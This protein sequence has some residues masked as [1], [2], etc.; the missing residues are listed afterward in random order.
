MTTPS[1]SDPQQRDPEFYS[2]DPHQQG[3]TLD[4]TQ[5]SN[6]TPEAVSDTDTP[7]GKLMSDEAGEKLNSIADNPSDD[8]LF[9]RQDATYLENQDHPNEGYDPHGQGYSDKDKTSAQ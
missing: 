5:E 1:A 4:N 9:H 2:N 6:L 3:E 8:A 7:K